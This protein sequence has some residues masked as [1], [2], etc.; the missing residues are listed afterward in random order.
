MELEGVGV[1]GSWRELEGGR[2]WREL[3]L[4][5]ELEGVDGE[6]LSS[7]RACGEEKNRNRNKIRR[8]DRGA[9]AAIT[10]VVRRRRGG[11]A[12]G[13]VEGVLGQRCGAR[14]RFGVASPS[15]S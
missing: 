11:G 14:A 1:G 2:S 13:Q 4:E 7:A 9:I 8:G 10:T 12:P 5:M 6:D 3:E 15:S